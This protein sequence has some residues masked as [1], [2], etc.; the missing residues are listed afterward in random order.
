MIIKRGISFRDTFQFI[1]KVDNNFSQRHIII[2][3][4]TI[5]RNIFLFHQ[6]TAFAQTQSHDGTDIIGSCDNG[7]TNIRLFNAV[8]QS[9]I[10]HTSGVMHLCHMTL[11][12][13]NIIRNV[14]HSSYHVHVEFTIK[15]FLHNLHVQE[16]QESATESKAQRQRGFRLEGQ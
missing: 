13:V 5:T 10:G 11:F 8:Y 9:R 16:S 1:I 12:V 2:D 6:F 3:F 7:S 14:R 15:A 4:H